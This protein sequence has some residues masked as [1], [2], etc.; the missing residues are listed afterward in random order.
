MRSINAYLTLGLCAAAPAAAAEP[1]APMP[2]FARDA[3][4]LFQGDSITDGNRGRTPDPN[5]ILG[6]GYALLIAAKYGSSLAERNLTFMNR[7]ISGNK[8]TDLQARWAADALELKPEVLSILIGINDAGRSVPCAEFEAG[9]DRLLADT[10]AALPHVRLVLCEPFQLPATDLVRQYQAA[11]ERLAAKHHT[12][13]VRL[14]KVFEDA[15]RRAPATYWIWDTVH[16]TYSGHQLIADEWVR[17][18]EE[19]H[20][21][22]TSDK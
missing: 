14:Q 1:A 7:G 20:H 16:P 19:F 13:L 2:V 3:R 11:T 9:C 6:H 8:V 15:C 10:L 5:H 17:T 12:P 4:I 22:V 18:V 21:Q